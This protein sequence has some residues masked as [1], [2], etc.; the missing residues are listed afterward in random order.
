[1]SLLKQAW[2]NKEERELEQIEIIDVRPEDEM[3][4][5]WDD[6]ILSHHYQVTGDF[7]DA[8]IARHPR[9]TCE[10]FWNQSMELQ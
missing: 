10:A 4:T 7:Y 2:R 6:F 9:R 1:M 5:S 8:W 3:R